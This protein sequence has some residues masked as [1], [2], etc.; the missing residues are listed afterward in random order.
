MLGNVT[1]ASAI[2]STG[3]ANIGD[4]LI[5]VG[6]GKL[7]LTMANAYTGGTQVLAGTLE[8]GNGGSLGTGD[9]TVAAEGAVA[10]VLRLDSN[11]TIDD[12]SNLFVLN[13]TGTSQIDLHF[14]SA[15]FEVVNSLTANGVAVAPGDYNAANLSDVLTGT[16]NL[17]VLSAVPGPGTVALLAVSAGLGLMVWRRRRA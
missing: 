3:T 6:S 4:A 5:K 8:I 2:T 15:L 16:G 7:A 12:I 11:T 17:R 14:D 10:A 9:V 13:G 1:I